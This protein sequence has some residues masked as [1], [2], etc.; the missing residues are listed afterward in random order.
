MPFVLSTL[1]HL[2]SVPNDHPLFLSFKPS[3]KPSPIQLKNG[4]RISTTESTIHTNCIMRNITT[5]TKPFANN[6]ATS[7]D[8]RKTR[9]SVITRVEDRL[10]KNDHRIQQLETRADSSIAK[11][12]G[13]YTRQ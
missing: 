3:R 10:N 8:T 2:S 1:S 11:Y 9:E 5:T 6:T 7:Y 13:K 12:T 4:R